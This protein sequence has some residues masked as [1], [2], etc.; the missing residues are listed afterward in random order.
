MLLI[1]IK[2]TKPSS[3]LGF[4]FVASMLCFKQEHVVTY[5]SAH[6]I[7]GLLNL[8]PQLIHLGIAQ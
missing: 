2:T 6:P 3:K 4:V 7:H 1:P 5:K 8:E